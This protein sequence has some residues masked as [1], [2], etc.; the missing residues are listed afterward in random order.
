MRQEG[1]GSP[2]NVEKGQIEKKMRK[3]RR[4][5]AGEQ[6]SIEERLQE[7]SGGEG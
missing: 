1:D 7:H 3:Q 4:K 6:E 5:N 2:Q